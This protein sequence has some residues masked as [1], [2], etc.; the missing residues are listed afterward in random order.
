MKAVIVAIVAILA[1]ALAQ[2]EAQ[3]AIQLGYKNRIEIKKDGGFISLRADIP[4]T[5]IPPGTLGSDAGFLRIQTESNAVS[6]GGAV[7][8]FWVNQ[9]GKQTDLT[10]ANTF[11]KAKDS[12]FPNFDY[13]LPRTASNA[14]VVIYLTI[15]SVSCSTCSSTTEIKIGFWVVQAA[16]GIAPPQTAKSNNFA[17]REESYTAQFSLPLNTYGASGWFMVTDKNIFINVDGSI[18]GKTLIALSYGAAPRQGIDDPKT[19]PASGDWD[20]IGSTDGTTGNYK[21]GGKFLK[22]GKWYFT[23]YCTSLTGV[24][25][26][27]IDFALGNGHE[28]AAANMAVPGL[29]VLLLVVVAALKNFL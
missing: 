24:S 19:K 21:S 28:P 10:K 2:E 9:D 26:V 15:R 6:A 18:A 29:T 20:V 23:P 13:K 8:D 27:S 14:T 11:G 1:V 7:V 22:A 12:S 5:E 16:D 17:L 25:S 3:Q 4:R